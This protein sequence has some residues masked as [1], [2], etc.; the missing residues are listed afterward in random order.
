[1]VKLRRSFKEILYRYCKEFMCVRTGIG[2][3][4]SDLLMILDA[5]NLV[6]IGIQLIQQ[7]LIEKLILIVSNYIFQ[8]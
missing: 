5:T 2:P 3:E 6:A 4:E 1:M 7:P 8:A